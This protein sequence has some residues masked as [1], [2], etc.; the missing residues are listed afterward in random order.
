[1]YV[2]DREKLNITNKSQLSQIIF[3]A[4]YGS[5]DLYDEYL[6]KLII[7]YHEQL[8]FDKMMAGIY[9][10]I[11]INLMVICLIMICLHL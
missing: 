3:L 4:K 7:I 9:L 10:G 5:L 11:A 6:E 1:M 2:E 8:Q